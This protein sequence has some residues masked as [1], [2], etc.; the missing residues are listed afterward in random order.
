MSDEAPTGTFACPI[1]G[2]E[3]PHGHS[4]MVVNA[5]RKAQIKAAQAEQ[6]KQAGQAAVNEFRAELDALR[7]EIDAAGRQAPAQ[8]EDG[9]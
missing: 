6:N 5:Y 4:E 8:P 7:S 9:R 3:E 1:C 2:K